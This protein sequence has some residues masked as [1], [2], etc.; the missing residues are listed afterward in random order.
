[1]LSLVLLLPAPDAPGDGWGARVT[2][3]APQGPPALPTALP[4]TI[5]IFPLDDA[6]LFPDMAVPLRIFE[7]RYRAMVADVLKGNR[8]I[9]MVQLRPG[10]EADYERSPSIFPLGVA[11]VIT[12][13]EMQP[14]GEY[15]LVLQAFAKFRVAREEAHQPYRLAHVAAISETVPDRDRAA[16]HAQRER[17]ASIL[18]TAGGQLGFRK[19]PDGI[20]D[21]QY[22]N[23]VS[24]FVLIDPLD[25]QRLLEQDSALSRVGVLLELIDR[26]LVR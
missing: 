24:Q 12:D 5:P 23:G 2:A 21:E 6:M 10:Y 19:I 22:V 15:T 13:V 1:V 8:I 16:L 18:S 9:G 17:L 4:E 11:G 26:L 14:N 20:S 25:R 7:P 3:M